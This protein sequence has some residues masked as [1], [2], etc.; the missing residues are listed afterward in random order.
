[1]NPIINS[2]IMTVGERE[3]ILVDVSSAF[4]NIGTTAIGGRMPTNND[5]QPSFEIFFVG[6]EPI[7]SMLHPNKKDRSLNK[8]ISQIGNINDCDD[9][10]RN[11]LAVAKDNYFTYEQGLVKSVQPVLEMLTD[12]LYVVHTSKMIPSDGSG[13]YFWNAY[14]TR[15]E[16]LGTAEQNS[17]M[18]ADNN[19]APCFLVPSENISDFSESK[20][21]TTRENIKIGKKFGGV[22]YHLSGMFSVLLSGHHTATACLLENTDFNCIVIE[23]LRDI[24]YEPV[25]RAVELGRIP[26]PIALSCP[27]VKIP[28]SAM[29][30]TTIDTFLMTRRSI[31]PVNFEILK[32][33]STRTLRVLSKRNLPLEV[34]Q[35]TELLPDTAMLESAQAVTSLSDEQLEALLS[36]E[37]SH[38]GEIIINNNYYNSV[39]IACNYLQYINYD[40]FIDFA[41]SILKNPDLTATHKYLIDRI[42]NITDEKV[43]DYFFDLY[44]NYKEIYPE[45]MSIAENYIKK[46]EQRAAEKAKELEKQNN[47]RRSLLNNEVD[48]LG[49]AQME[50][51]IKRTRGG[52][53]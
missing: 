4:N 33:K 23:P 38:N 31:K 15:H 29:P 14:L 25:E 10:V 5:R 11:R 53:G 22:A 40:K 13:N 37:I 41:I 12:G 1:M 24:M 51:F 20:I 18:G 42:A 34:Y 21:R 47:A 17:V 9:S 30:E 35:K 43:K 16:V 49:L 48:S 27:F 7:V 50:A 39:V 8:L 36:G 26:R 46:Y 44:D 3:F 2:T 28:L 6:D 32:A 19:Y 52:R 45:R